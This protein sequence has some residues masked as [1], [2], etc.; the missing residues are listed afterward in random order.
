MPT[1][2]WSPNQAAVAQVETYTYTVPSG[3]GN[4]YTATINGKTVTYSSISGDTAATVA[5]AH[6][7]LLN[8]TANVPLELTEIQFANTASATVTATAKVAGTPFANVTVNGVSG[9]GL[10]MSTGNGLAN[11]ITTVHTT[12]N[13][14]PSDVFDTQNWLRVVGANPAVRAIPANG[15]DVIVGNSGTP[16]LWNLDRLE[17]VEFNTYRRDQSQT[18]VVGLPEI[19]PVGYIEWR[20]TYFKFS[21]PTGSAPTGGLSMVLGFDTGSGGGP[22][23]ER[24][25]LGSS[26]FTIQ[27]LAA[28]SPIDEY[29][30]RVLGQHTDNVIVASGGVSIAVAMLSGE[31]SRLNSVTANSGATIAIG[32][33]VTWSTNIFGTLN[34]CMMYGGFILLN[35]APATLSLNNGAAATFATSD[36]TWPAITAQGG[37][38]LTFLAGGTITA[39]TLT[40]GCVFDKSQDARQLTVTNATIDG[41]SCVIIDTLN[42]MVF[43]NPVTVKQQVASG[44]FQFTGS[45][46][47]RV[48]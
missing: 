23:R 9:Q 4:T 42:S 30:I 26:R 24:Y 2:F 12:A 31:T 21:G 15:D 38:S 47:V 43:T 36:L 32:V 41:D 40:V 19:N 5:T 8:Q 35:S 7:N 27:A 10:V 46:T 45:R 13:K 44:P 34:T 6:F 39:L 48:I 33:G 16:L 11:G 20:A 18:G 28:G 29:G 14:S 1:T 17:A 37:C 3:V 25:D 22:N